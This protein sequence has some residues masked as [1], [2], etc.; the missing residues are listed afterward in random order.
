MN[1]SYPINHDTVV[2]LI[3]L[4]LSFNKTESLV[5]SYYALPSLLTLVR[6][7]LPVGF[8]GRLLPSECS[9]PS[10]IDSV[11]NLTILL[12]PYSVELVAVAV[13]RSCS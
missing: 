4:L 10:A 6:P 12:S 1:I 7:S 3:Y 8:P 5:T 9:R 2:R 11:I 13:G